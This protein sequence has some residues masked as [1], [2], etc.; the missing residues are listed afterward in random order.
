MCP[1]SASHGLTE[2]SQGD[3]MGLRYTPVDFGAEKSPGT[4]KTKTQ[5]DLRQNEESETG[6]VAE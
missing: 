1:G 4:P 6:S 5:Y 2:Y 3:I